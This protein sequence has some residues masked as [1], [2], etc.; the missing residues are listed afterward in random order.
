[1]IGTRSS[2]ALIAL[3]YQKLHRVSPSTNKKFDSGQIVNFVQV[4]AQMLFWLCF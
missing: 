3:I 4:D 2:N 1:M